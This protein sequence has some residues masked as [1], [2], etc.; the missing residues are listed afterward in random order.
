VNRQSAAPS[1][2]SNGPRRISF[3]PAPLTSAP[4]GEQL[5]YE[6]WVRARSSLPALVIVMS[7]AWPI[8]GESIRKA[9]VALGSYVAIF[10][11]AAI[12]WTL[13]LVVSQ[14]PTRLSPRARY[15]AMFVGALASGLAFGT[16]LFAMFAS[17]DALRLGLFIMLAAGILSGA[18][19]SL[20]ARPEIFF[21]YT[22]PAV[23]AFVFGPQ[24]WPRENGGVISLA[25]TTW[26][27]Y[28]MLQV[29]QYKKTRVEFITL[30]HRLDANV[31]ALDEKNQALERAHR[32]TEG[33]NRELE[34]KNKELVE[35]HQRADRIFAALADALPGKTLEGKYKLIDRIGAGG[36]SVVFRGTH[37]GLQRPVAV[38]VFR[39]QAGNDSAAALERFKV[40]GMSSSLVH[41]PNIVQVLDAGVSD[42][43]IAYLVMELLDG[44]ALDAD[45][46]TGRPLPVE[47]TAR[48]MS[49]VCR[50]LA[51]AHASGVIHRDVKP[52]NIFL[53][54]DGG[55]EIAKL[56]DFGIAKVRDE[57]RMHGN[58][59][60]STGAFIGTPI[61]MAPE[62]FLGRECDASAD[63]YS[64]GVI[65]YR[66]FS[67]K[68]PYDGTLGEIMM[69]VVSERPRDLCELAPHV[70]PALAAL[71][72][73]ALEDDPQRR[74]TVTELAD[75]LDFACGIVSSGAVTRAGAA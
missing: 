36:F 44:R 3:A 38:K 50:G 23:S 61:Y 14:R 59:L 26:I 68:L 74:P 41:H 40:E 67:G 64:V 42:E 4:T 7:F 69:Q 24:I 20:G 16:F 60:T 11:I 12:R 18:T 51:A 45:L 73:G 52:E 39:P 29:A 55:V 32:E 48:V 10:G 22:A 66:L 15:L 6:L 54:H 2:R 25:W 75:A 58:H 43:G 5:V 30:N 33:K 72:M 57:A 47:R 13:A 71:V 56:L 63:V 31:K 1:T 37:L 62:R 35:L 34:E 17:L 46:V 9:P 49:Q 53:H 70:R 28:S 27:V 21:V 19:T 65:L 8:S